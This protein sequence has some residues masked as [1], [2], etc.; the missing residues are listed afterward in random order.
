MSV[1]HRLY[2]DDPM[3]REFSRDPNRMVI[4]VDPRLS[5]TARMSDM[6]IQ[7]RPGSDSL[8]LRT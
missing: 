6:H 5:E 2:Y 7:V 4:V 1:S 3:I 8:F